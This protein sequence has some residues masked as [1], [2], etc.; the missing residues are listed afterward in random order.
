LRDYLEIL[1]DFFTRAFGYKTL[2]K[3]NETIENE[4]FQLIFTKFGVIYGKNVE[5]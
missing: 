3:P 1:E 5:I 2:K 4:V